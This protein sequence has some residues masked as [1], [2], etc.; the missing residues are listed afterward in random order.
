MTETD[1]SNPIKV[2]SKVSLV[3]D[4]V[5]VAVETVRAPKTAEV[6]N[7]ATQ[8]DYKAFKDKGVNTS[9]FES[10]KD[11]YEEL[12]KEKKLLE[13]KLESSEDSRIQAQKKQSLELDKVM[14]QAKKEAETVSLS[15]SL[16]S[17]PLMS[18]YCLF[19][20]LASQVF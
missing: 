12:L 8:T 20:V 4:S 6:V 5:S 14:K 9:P 7:A 3:K 17:S 15:L 13:T 1:G 10:F 11:K 2:E 18:Y 19:L 16:L